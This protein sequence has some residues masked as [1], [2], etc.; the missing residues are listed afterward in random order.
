MADLGR[1]RARAQAGGGPCWALPA[2]LL[3]VGSSAEAGAACEPFSH[4]ISN[5]AVS[6][7]RVL[8]ASGPCV[9]VLRETTPAPCATAPLYCVNRK[10]AVNKL[11]LPYAE[12]E[13]GRLITCWT[14]PDGICYRGSLEGPYPN[15]TMPPENEIMDHFI[16][17]SPGDS[18]VGKMFYR[19]PDWFLAV[20]SSISKDA[21]DNCTNVE[22]GSTL[23]I[24]RENEIRVEEKNSLTACETPYFMDIFLWGGHLFFPYYHF[25][26]RSIAPKMLII[27]EAYLRLPDNQTDEATLPYNQ[28][29]LR[30]AN[31]SRI[32][33]SSQLSLPE[34]RAFWIGIFTSGEEPRTPTSTALCL[35]DLKQVLNDARGCHLGDI[36]RDLANCH[37]GSEEIPDV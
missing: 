14:Q 19:S 32:L 36:C 15:G 4:R 28:A 25:S 26:D 27:R 37:C 18:S 11:L 5:L 29:F 12:E 24:L 20:A 10:D 22:P 9:Y 30:C 2:L 34:D 7:G 35:F 6:G 23:Y 17:C 33:S 13:G 3:L 8:V 31:K 16:S 1:R 21:P